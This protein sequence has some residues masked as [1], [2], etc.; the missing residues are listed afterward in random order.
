[1]N[2][3]M[4]EPAQDPR[5]VNPRKEE[6]MNYKVTEQEVKDGATFVVWA[7]GLTIAAFALAAAFGISPSLPF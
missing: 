5:R 3:Y 7:I 4:F 1:M 2:D 6:V